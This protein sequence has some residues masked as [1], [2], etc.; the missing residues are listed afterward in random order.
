MLLLGMDWIKT[1]QQT[2]GRIHM[3]ENN[4]SQKEKILMKLPNLFENND[5]IKITA[6]IF[7]LK[8][9]DY[10]VKQQA[11]PVPPHLQ[12]DVGR[13]LEKLIRSGHLEKNIDV[14]EDCI[15]S[16]LG[17]TVKSDKSVKIA[18][19]SRKLND[20]C[21]IMKPHL[22]TIEELLNQILV[23]ITVDPIVQM[24]KIDL[25]FSYGQ[26]KLSEETR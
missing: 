11:R 25:D 15:V 26:M 14:E 23:G 19:A 5:T 2:I 9:G 24:F 17:I 22:P 13:E 10:A 18:L 12:E 16:S 20:S 6:I 1:F 4:Q 7:Q 8:L 21:K 3:A